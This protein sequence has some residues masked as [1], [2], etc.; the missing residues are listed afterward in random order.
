MRLAR[1]TEKPILEPIEEH[2]WERA[3]VF[4]S[5][6]VERDGLIHMLYRAM[7]RPYGA[8]NERFVSSIGYAVSTDGLNFLRFDKPVFQGE[9][10]QEH[11]GVEDPRIVWL[12]GRYYMTYTA[13]GGRKDGDFKISM[14]STTDFLRWQRHGVLLDESN[15]NGVLFPKKIADK[16][17]LI[18][19]RSPN[20]WLATSDDFKNWQD[21][22][23]LLTTIPDSWQETRVGSAGP[24][25]ETEEGWLFFYHAADRNNVYRLGLAILDLDDPN[26]VLFRTKEPILEPELPWEKEGLV[27]NVV[28]SC[29]AIKWNGE[30]LVYYS[31]ADKAIGVAKLEGLDI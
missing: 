22:K 23:P 30:Y 6:V 7:D 18:H 5:A 8:P 4:N 24:P 31:G 21:H 10:P 3:A 26:K 1:L 25:I 29:G 14:A 27:P 12:D 11:W 13:F 28:F 15:K 17:L 2:P 9:G 16:Y 20:I 19:R